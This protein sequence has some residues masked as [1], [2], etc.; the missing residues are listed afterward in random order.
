MD[1]ILEKYHIL[2][3]QAYPTLL[4]EYM[5]NMKFVYYDIHY[6][7]ELCRSILYRFNHHSHTDISDMTNEE[8]ILQYENIKNNDR[9]YKR[10]RKSAIQTLRYFINESTE[11]HT[12]FI[13]EL[14]R[15]KFP[16]DPKRLTHSH[17]P[18]PSDFFSFLDFVEYLNERLRT[19][20]RPPLIRS[21]DT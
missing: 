5:Y 6:N 21:T 17:D 4:G 20:I 7:I 16:I 14:K 13:D 3:S 9:L 19:L 10:H 18:L 1:T 12:L 2:T 8:V 11:V 15:R